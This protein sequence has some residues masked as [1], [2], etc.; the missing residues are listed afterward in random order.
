MS[1]S[2]IP[3]PPPAVP[4][5]APLPPRSW[6]QRRVLDPLLDQLKAGL[7]PGQLALTVGLG[8]AIGLIPAFGLTTLLSAA[9]AL[10]L[11]LN[12]A[13]MQLATHLMTFFQLALL[14]PLLRAGAILMGQGD[15]VANLTVA[16]LRQLIDREGWEAVGKLLWRAELGALLLWA[17]GGAM[18]V[19]VLYLVLKP[20]FTRIVA[21]QVEEVKS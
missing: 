18:L 19:G 21:R 6:L 8:V 11:R 13:I 3:L 14:I 5:V 4:P 17:A 20:V 2:E 12:V 10:R 7:A 16:S 15:K 9:V 1:P